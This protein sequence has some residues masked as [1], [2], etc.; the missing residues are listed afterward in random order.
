[1]WRRIVLLSILLDLFWICQTTAFL[2]HHDTDNNKKC[3]TSYPN[4][5]LVSDYS[6]RRPLP[7][8]Q[9]PSVYWKPVLRSPGLQASPSPKSGPEFVASSSERSISP[10]LSPPL[11]PPKKT[12]KGKPQDT[13]LEWLNWLYRRWNNVPPGK[14]DAQ[15]LKHMVPAISIYAKRR[16]LPAACS[17]YALLQRYIQEYQAGNAH[18]VLTTTMFNAAMDAYAKIGQPAR[19]QEILKQMKELAVANNTSTSTYSATI[20]DPTCQQRRQLSLLRPDVIS[21]TTLAT[22]WTKSRNPQAAT[23]AQ[24]V[25]EYMEQQ[26]L[27]MQ[28]TTVL[29]N[30]VLNALARSS[31]PDKAQR[32][33]KLV[34]RMQERCALV[35]FNSNEDDELQLLHACCEPS[36]YTY[37]SLISCYSRSSQS[38]E[39]AEQVLSFLKRQAADHGRND[40]E[41]NTHCFAAAIHAWAY[42]MQPNKAKRAYDLL[43]EIRQRHER[44]G[45]QSVCQP[46]VVV[47]TAALN[48]CAKPCLPEERETAF[49]IAVLIMEE[50]KNAPAKYGTANFLTYA[51]FLR[52]CA[53]TLP[54]STGSSSSER[55][56]AVVRQCFEQCCLT[57]H[58]G[59][60]V[61]D[62]L[63]DAAS[64]SLYRQLLEGVEDISFSSLP[65]DWTRNVKG[66]RRGRVEAVAS[67]T[68][69]STT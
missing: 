4:D 34:A 47:Y 69:T 51:A 67:E 36:I 37:Q 40:L 14:L 7:S 59:Q 25:L 45:Q 35:Q 50:L 44:T 56:D 39:R 65:A 28:P 55:R 49:D 18:A 24:A 9:Q 6:S 61:L 60:I 48:A 33:E 2:S 62:K 20:S 11:P 17:A 53:T 58:V 10:P 38:P 43:Q 41:P 1:M 68:P 57:G 31:L 30:V 26:P 23:K 29:Y 19:V 5:R 27:D 63:A 52:A 8:P 32:A 54:D 46:N 64:P 66:E 22:A 16:S 13:E 3:S 42:S 21:L 12:T 15:T